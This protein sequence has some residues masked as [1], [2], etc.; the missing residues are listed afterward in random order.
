[1]VDEREALFRSHRIDSV[2]A[3]RA[4]VDAG[5]LPLPVADV[6]LLVDGYGQLGGDF[7][8]L[9]PLVHDVLARGGAYGVHVVASVTRFGEVRTGQQAA[10]ANRIE[11]RLGDP[12][13]SLIDRKLA[14][15][16]RA[17]QPGRALRDDG[18]LAQVAL[19]RLDG[20]DATDDLAEGLVKAAIGVA[21]AWAGDDVPAVR[22]LPAELP[23]A[24]LPWEL[25]GEP[26]TVD[27]VPRPLFP[28]GLDERDLAPVVL[29]LG[30]VDQ[31]VLVL[32]DPGAGKTC[33][34][35]LLTSQLVARF[36]DEQLV[37]AVFDPR[38]RL[39]GVV[40]EPWLGGYADGP[41]QAAALA[42]SVAAELE[43][44]RDGTVSVIG[45]GPGSPPRVVLLVDDYDVLEAAG[46]DPLAVLRPH[47]ASGRDI[48]VH[49]VLT[50]RVA[51]AGRG[52]FDRTVLAMREAG[53]TTLV[54]SGDRSEGQLVNGVRA[55]PL[56]PGRALLSRPGSPPVT[57]QLAV[58]DG[59]LGTADA[60]A[61]PVPEG[62]AGG[63]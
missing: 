4:A 16:I 42:A 48:G 9:A 59:S 27:G 25:P 36:T 47:L 52:L 3:M 41:T 2:E 55:M 33:L 58:P 61:Q 34:M 6:V 1:M 23:A 38:R 14:R 56:P 62:M 40:P 54:M 29:D 35:R 44:R 30:G 39:T 28:I 50:R 24:R 31:H 10:F 19:P 20:S 17:D 12:A 8:D 22:T 37:L 21:G 46:T 18:L 63:A 7:E 57:V 26:A 60:A 53:G 32:G 49:L 13:D 11:L 15:T 5:R 51:G 43:R 45:A